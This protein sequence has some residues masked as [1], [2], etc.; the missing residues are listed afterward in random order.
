M[1]VS[2]ISDC[3]FLPS[4]ANLRQRKM[5]KAL[6]S[7]PR[8]N[9]PN[10]ILDPEDIDKWNHVYENVYP[11]QYNKGFNIPDDTSYL[12]RLDHNYRLSLR[13]EFFRTR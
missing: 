3:I 6:Y 9:H 13:Y 10:V 11:N 5:M 2:E 4:F 1:T 12:F 8:L 7:V